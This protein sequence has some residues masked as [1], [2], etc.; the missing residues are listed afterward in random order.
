MDSSLRIISDPYTIPNE[1]I[2]LLQ[3][4]LLSIAVTFIALYAPCRC[5]VVFMQPLVP[6]DSVYK[7]PHK[8]DHDKNMK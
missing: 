2:L 3:L 1:C 5:I 7:E 6:D 4:V 8:N